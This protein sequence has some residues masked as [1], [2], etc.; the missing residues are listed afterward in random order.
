MSALWSIRF[1]SSETPHN[2]LNRS[3]YAWS[4]R[5]G[6]EKVS[7]LPGIES[8]LFDRPAHSENTTRNTIPATR[9]DGDQ[10]RE[11]INWY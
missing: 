3:L 7:S 4:R 11:T 9:D 1:I 5:F 2:P 8:K 10:I 6:G